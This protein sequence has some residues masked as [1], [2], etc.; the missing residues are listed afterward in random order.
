[1]DLTGKPSD[2]DHKVKSTTSG[3]EESPAVPPMA[4]IRDDDELLL[5]RIGY[6]QELRREFSKWSTV[7][8][9]ISILGVLGSVPATFG[10]PL[11]AG[12]PATAV[13]CW[14]IGSCMAMC[15]GSSVAEL[16]SA[17]PTA[18]GMYFVTKHVV[19]ADQVPIFS[20]IQGW[21]NLLG[22]TAGVSSVAYTISQMLLACVSMNSDLVDGKYSYTPTALE[23]VLVSIG[24]LCIIGIICSLTTKTL[25]RIILW[26]APINMTATVCI[27]IAL[28]YLTPDKQPASWVFTHFTD[29]S[30]WGSKVFSF[31]L[32]FLSVA[33][34]MTDYD[35]TTHMSEETHDAAIRGPVAIQT[36]VLVSGVFG[37]LLTVSMCFC[38]TDFESILKSPT[39]L[40]AAQIFLNA[41][42]KRGGTAM[43]AF[44]ILVQFF[45]GCS[46]ML[47]DTRM[48]YAFAR[49]EALPFSKFISK[50]NP[51]THTP[52]N[53][54]WF[55]V[56]FSVALNCI[57]IGSTQ[58]ATAIFSVT[59]PALDIS[60][61]SVILAHQIYKTKVKFIEGPFTL[62]KWGTPINYVAIVWVMFISTILFFPSQIPVTTANMN[63]AVCVAAFIAAF[64]LIWWWL[65]A[66]GNY[67]GPQTNDVIQELPTED[68]GDD[69]DHHQAE[70]TV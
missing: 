2:P 29:G 46:A 31:F 18:G 32:G 45:T 30:G 23:T 67:T 27:C 22:Q 7:S 5:A 52:V 50:V 28:L 63:Y 3:A 65:T 49:D 40:P 70:I 25:H 36:A 69:F 57:A 17:Y 38:L 43:W 39:G 59:A 41:G 35:G 62:K 15:I 33:W 53:A 19:P 4:T 51:M 12:G 1:M 11:A 8:Y 42:G 55:V 16:V 21:C 24:L 44:A 66:R 9:A 61:V 34:T 20:W 64:A 54:V 48:A 10:S 13:W 68:D 58:T 56:F 37:W 26:F 14:L 60:Y 6:K 47:A